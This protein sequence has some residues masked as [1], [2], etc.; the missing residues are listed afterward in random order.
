MEP[1]SSKALKKFLEDAA[2]KYKVGMNDLVYKPCM[3]PLEFA[4]WRVIKGFFSMNLTTS[5]SKYI[6]KY[7]KHPKIL[8]VLEF[9]ILFLGAMPKDTPALYSLMNYADIEL[10]TWY[11][12]G[13]MKEISKAFEYILKEQGVEILTNNEVTGFEYDQGKISSV[14]AGGKSYPSDAVISGAD[15]HHTDRDFG[16]RKIELF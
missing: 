1:G 5:F 14:L 15:Y 7:F 12:M 11:P 13:G 8:S 2:Y 9:P 4:D 6:R 3:S 16:R 10:G